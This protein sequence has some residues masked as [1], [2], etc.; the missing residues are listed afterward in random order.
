MKLEINYKK[1]T[2]KFMGL[3]SMLLNNQWMKEEV[4]TEIKKYLETNENRK[5][6]YQN[7]WNAA[8]VVFRGKFTAINVYMLKQERSQI[9]KLTLH[10]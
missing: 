5:T 1:K 10:L 6:T 8:K 4:K 3:N 9:K 7:L 2:G